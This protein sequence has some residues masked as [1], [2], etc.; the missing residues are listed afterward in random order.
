MT[1]DQYLL[2]G[3]ELLEKVRTTQAGNIQKAAQ[4]MAASIAV[5]RAVHMFGSGH[6]V[7]PVLDMFPRYGSYVGFHP[8]MDARLQ[9]QN[10]T[11]SGGA[12]EL[13]WLERQEGYMEV[14]MRS[15]KHKLDSRDCM[16]LY[17]HSGM[18]A[19]SI[20]LALI[21]KAQGLTVI[22]V[23]CGPNSAVNKPT[24]SSGKPLHAIA[25]IVIDNCSPVEDA[26][27][28]VDGMKGNVAASSTLTFIAITQA[29]LAEV[30]TELGKQGKLPPR[31]FVSPNVAD[32]PKDNNMQVFVDYDAWVESL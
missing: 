16:L 14:V 19:A 20:D 9:W 18:N 13:I 29:L 8:I 4:A 2:K 30:T 31:A 3:I 21:A 23:T 7:I 24:H 26:I 11:G 17:S 6:S 5:G 27:I 10:V 12:Q 22:A 32:V 15:H 28:S 1:A 25:D